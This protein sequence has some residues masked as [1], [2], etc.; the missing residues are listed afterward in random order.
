MAPGPLRPR[1]ADVRGLLTLRAVHD[2]ELGLLALR[3]AA[4]AVTGDGREVDEDVVAVGTGDEPVPL[5]VAEPFHRSLR[6]A[7]PSLHPVH[8]QRT[9]PRVPPSGNRAE[10]STAIRSNSTTSG[11]ANAQVR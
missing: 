7:R 3:E 6:H 5:L 11:G 8:A 2:V 1:G 9:G 10:R 4:V